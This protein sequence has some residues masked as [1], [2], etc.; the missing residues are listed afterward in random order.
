MLTGRERLNRHRAR[1]LLVELHR[2][3]SRLGSVLTVMNT[4]AHPDDEQSGLLALLRFERG[5]RVVIACSTRGEGGQNGIGP[6]RGTRLGALRSREMEAAAQALDADIAWLGFGPDDPVHDF[7]FSKDGADTLR[8]WGRERLLE[9]LVR[10]YRRDRPDIVVPTFL[11]VPGQHGHHRA[12]TEAA[13]TAIALAAD[14]AAFPEHL[15]EGLTPWQ[16]A[17]FYLPAWSGGGG[18]YDDEV[19]PPNAS[20]VVAATGPDP[21]TG[22][23]YDELGEVSRAFHATQGMG[24]WSPTPRQSWPLHLALGPDGAETDIADHLPADLGALGA[25]LG[26]PTGT[27]LAAAQQAIA[28]A[29]A[30]FPDRAAIATALAAAAAQ[31]DMA[32]AHLTVDATARH[33][34]RLARKRVE[35]DAALAL[36][37]GLAAGAWLEPAALVPGGTATLVVHAT[38]PD[39]ADLAITPRLPAGVTAGPATTADGLTRLPLAIAADA[40]LTTPFAETFSSLGAATGVTL[41]ATVAGRRLRLDIPFEEPLEIVPVQTLALDPDALVVPLGRLPHNADIALRRDG[42]PAPVTLAPLTGVTA[43]ETPAGLHLH[44]D[45]N[46]AAGRHQLG[47][48]LGGAPAHS[49]AT[50]AY[51]HIAPV[52][53]ALPQTLGLL[54]LDLSLPAGARLGYVGG[55]SDRVGLWLRRMGL[56]VTDLDAEALAGDLAAYTTIVIGILAFGRRP[57]LAAATE[58]LHRWVEAGGH[59]LT[60]YHRPSD[61]W[62]PDHTPPR[63]LVIGSPSLRWRVTDPAAPVEVLAPDHALLAGPNRIGPDDW[64]GWDKERGLYFAAQ[65]DDAYV[66]LLAMHDA[67]EAPLLGSLLSAPVGRGRHTHTS[68]VLHHQLDRLVPGAFRLMANLVQPA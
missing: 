50:L 44:L 37:G 40:P 63:R 45:R 7:G 22:L 62:D 51:P 27:A 17:K 64:A 61:G 68:L 54:A 3:L 65:W 58:R 21:A 12:M 46:L 47:L 49:I 23:A 43:A 34:H 60:L 13:H 41:E 29:T 1:P 35:I 59:L 9:R 31:I 11:D 6:E 24:H 67:G 2:A 38:V 19:P 39:A 16:V 66:P 25:A 26:G 30:A 56:S 32:A 15:I 4:G 52:H 33:G 57:D 48:A 18:T 53:V 55:G 8:R 10:A 36:A 14:P 42:P 20:L 28:T 5:L